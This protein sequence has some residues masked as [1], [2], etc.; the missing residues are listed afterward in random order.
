MQGKLEDEFMLQHTEFN[1]KADTLASCS[2]NLS[3]TG[4]I[5]NTPAELSL[6]KESKRV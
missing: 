2:P 3:S 4:A 6:R 5:Y 1:R